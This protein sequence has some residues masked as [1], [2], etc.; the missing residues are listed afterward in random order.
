MQSKC[1]V[2]AE[3]GKDLSKEWINK[4]LRS[5][6]ELCPTMAYAIFSLSY[7]INKIVFAVKVGL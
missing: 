5:P 7:L 1:A 2:L 6:K 3:G 4:T